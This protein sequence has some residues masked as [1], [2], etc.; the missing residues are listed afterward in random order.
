MEGD[1]IRYPLRSPDTNFTA[2]VQLGLFRLDCE[3]S[4]FSLIDGKTQYMVA[5]ATR[6][7]SLSYGS[8]SLA[9]KDLMLGTMLMDKSWGVCPR[10]MDF[11]TDKSGTLVSTDANIVA[12]REKYIIKDFLADDGFKN[13]PY[14]TDW[15]HMRSYAEV[16]VTSP[17]G[18]VI[19]GYCS[20]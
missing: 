5:E 14:V 17:S 2:L 20:M 19:G 1:G 3:R 8:G 18:H 7:T 16:P 10:T 9:Q 11:F 12:D 15:P 4:F 13:R 6:K